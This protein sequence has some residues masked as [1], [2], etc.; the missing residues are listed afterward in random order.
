VVAVLAHAFA[1]GQQ[2][3]NTSLD[4][5]AYENGSITNNVYTNECFG[6]SLAIPE[7]W[8]LKPVGADGK[9]TH[10]AKN[11]LIL[12]VLDRHHEGAFKSQIALTA[13]ETGGSVVTAQQLVSNAVRA[14]IDG[15]KNFHSELVRD[16][17]AV[18]YGD[19]RLFRADYKQTINGDPRYM[20]FVYTKFRGFYIGESLG[21]VSPGELEMAASSLQGISFQEDKSNPKCVMKGDDSHSGGVI[22]GVLSSKPPQPEIATPW[23]VRISSGVAVGLLIKTVPPHY[24]DL[25]KQKR[26]Q[27]QV[28]LQADVDENGNVEQ[29][30]LISGDSMLATAAIEAVQQWKYKPYLL[31]GQPVKVETQVIVN[32]QLAAR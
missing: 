4:A 14:Q 12:M 25:A 22:G 17:Y 1:L 31:N 13:R 10:V 27:G 18:D 2:L 28:I 30:K 19:R 15:D 16:T 5:L 9:A 23:R 20:A 29:L 21:A 3:T 7:G 24:P 32:F 26:V 11:V 6:F 8:Q